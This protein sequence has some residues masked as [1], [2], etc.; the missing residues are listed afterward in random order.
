MSDKYYNLNLEIKSSS[1]IIYVEETDEQNNSKINYKFDVPAIGL[2]ENKISDFEKFF[3][4]IKK[5]IYLAEQNQKCTFKEIILILDNF[6]TSFVNLSGYKKLNGS[7]I[8]RENITYILNTLKLY[9]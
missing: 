4:S 7:Q 6:N 3:E 1:F 5:N 8:L 2:E 9:E